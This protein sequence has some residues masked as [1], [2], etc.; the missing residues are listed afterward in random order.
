MR[1]VRNPGASLTPLLGADQMC[2]HLPTLAII[3]LVVTGAWALS[4]APGPSGAAGSGLGIGDLRMSVTQVIPSQIDNAVAINT[5]FY[6]IGGISGYL[7]LG[8]AA[9]TADEVAAY[10]RVT[11]EAH[12]KGIATVIG[13]ECATSLVG[14]PEGRTQWFRF[15]DDHW[16][17]YFPDV[18]DSPPEEWIQQDINGDPLPSWFSGNVGGI[19]YADY[20]P[21]CPNDPHWQEYHKLLV[22]LVNYDVERVD[23]PITEQG[24]EAGLI[25]PPVRS[26]PTILAPSQAAVRPAQRV[27]VRLHL[28]Q[29]AEVRNAAILSPDP[30]TNDQDLAWQVERG[31]GR[32]DL[33]LTIPEIVIYSVLSIDMAPLPP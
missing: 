7:G 22:H 30:A 16:A 27:V 31:D 12:R 5:N 3:A 32:T 23:I 4:A 20:H 24:I 13:Y 17:D 1:Q 2:C 18:P 25:H 33:V 29:N 19:A 28:P 21:A 26:S 6:Q 15:Y 14:D 11:D 10:R 9:A 8:S